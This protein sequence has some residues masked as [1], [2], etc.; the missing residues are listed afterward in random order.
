MIEELD[1]SG[2][3]KTDDF[4]YLYKKLAKRVKAGDVPPQAIPLFRKWIELEELT[5]EDTGMQLATFLLTFL[6]G[7]DEERYNF[8]FT[9]IENRIQ[10]I[11]N[12]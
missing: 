10:E 6:A 7:T 3:L 12:G 8:I 9:Y 5:L 11:E 2:F 1:E 4:E